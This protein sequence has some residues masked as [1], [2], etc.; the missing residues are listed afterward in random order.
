MAR[1]DDANPIP[2]P[3]SSLKT[4]VPS[5]IPLRAGTWASLVVA[6]LCVVSL[7]AGAQTL[8]EDFW[9]VDGPVLALARS[10]NTLYVG[11]EFTHAG[12]VTGGAAMVD[13][14][15]GKRI[16]AFPR[17]NGRVFAVIPDGAGGWYMGGGFGSVGGIPRGNLAHIRADHTVSE[18]APHPDG[19]V[20]TLL[21]H[22]GVLYVGGDF[23]HIDGQ[24]RNRLAAF[25]VA[26]GQ[27]NSWDPNA[28][29]RVTALA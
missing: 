15:G 10:G 23:T 6:S 8:R 4:P 5:W 18:W 25:D 13:P 16:A 1:D 3:R 14:I 9:A 29:A 21:L 7:P 17:A 20:Y 24:A 28:R 12:P 27:I 26:T 22:E 11:G 19:G 2:D